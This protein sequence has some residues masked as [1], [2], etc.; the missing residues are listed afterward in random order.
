MFSLLQKIPH[1]SN[2]IDSKKPDLIKKHKFLLIF[3]MEKKK[4]RV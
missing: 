2:I 3:F 4:V 1:L